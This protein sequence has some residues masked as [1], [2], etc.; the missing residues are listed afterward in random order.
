MNQW[1]IAKISEISGMGV[2][3][4]DRHDNLW[5]L[6]SP[7]GIAPTIPRP[8]R[9]ILIGLLRYSLEQLTLQAAFDGFDT[10][11]DKV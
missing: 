11:P 10:I 7:T 5:R 9:D 1:S 2:W 3:H 6:D 4:I 8:D